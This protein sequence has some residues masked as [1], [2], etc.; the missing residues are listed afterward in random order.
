MGA[1]RLSS[2]V[3]WNVGNDAFTPE[4]EFS[5]GASPGM[6]NARPGEMPGG[7]IP[8]WNAAG[9]AFAAISF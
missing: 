1:G 2:P 6:G 9:S 4:Y 8:R 5:L 3:G 7:R